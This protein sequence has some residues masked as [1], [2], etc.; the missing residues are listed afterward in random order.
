MW[1]REVFKKRS[2]SK[3]QG[4]QNMCNVCPTQWSRS[5]GS[6]TRWDADNEVLP[7]VHGTLL[8]ITLWDST[9]NEEIL[10]SQLRSK[11]RKW[12]LDG[13][14]TFKVCQTTGL[15]KSIWGSDQRGR[16]EG[17]QQHWV[18]LISLTYKDWTTGQVIAKTVRSG[19][20][21]SNSR[22]TEV[23]VP[24][25]WFQPNVQNEQGVKRR[26]RMC[27]RVCVHLCEGRHGL[28][29]LKTASWTKLLGQVIHVRIYK[30][31]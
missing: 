19:G 18:D 4:L 2:L 30:R 29:A 15:R 31:S 22:L 28:S 1:R 16:R 11:W 6:H 14:G 20:S 3:T 10:N 13:L 12:G 23:Q 25:E 8:Y 26:R 21:W 5:L 27:V 24:D 17:T 9:R 7:Y